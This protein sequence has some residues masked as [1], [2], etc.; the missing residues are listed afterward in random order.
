MA[1]LSTHTHSIAPEAD[2]ALS[3]GSCSLLVRSLKLDLNFE[4]NERTVYSWH[5]MC[6]LKCG[7]HQVKLFFWRSL[8]LTVNSVLQGCGCFIL[9]WS[10]QTVQE[11]VLPFWELTVS[12]AEKDPLSS[13]LNLLPEVPRLLL[14]TL[15]L[16][17]PNLPVYLN[18]SMQNPFPLSLTLWD[19]PPPNW[20]LAWALA[21][22]FRK[23]YPQSPGPW[24]GRKWFLHLLWL[25]IQTSLGV[26]VYIMIH[27]EYFPL[28]LGFSSTVCWLLRT[29]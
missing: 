20:A 18:Q 7:S 25:L 5:F 3:I 17:V 16:G 11:A 27:P 6:C 2:D 29:A 22:E 1:G 10:P 23:E 24:L 9:K 8:M 13:P 28:L 4:T 12:S 15:D 19:S 14:L 26:I 21:R